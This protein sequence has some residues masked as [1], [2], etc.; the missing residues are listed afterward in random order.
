MDEFMRAVAALKIDV[1]QI[2]Y[3]DPIS[4]RP[5]VRRFDTDDQE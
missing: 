1:V 4:H 5:V 3:F 2:N